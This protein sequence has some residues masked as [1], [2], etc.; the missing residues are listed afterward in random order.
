M[1]ACTA[2]KADGKYVQ[3]SDRV[4]QL[5]SIARLGFVRRSR[6]PESKRLLPAAYAT[7]S[8]A[9]ATSALCRAR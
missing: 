9:T 6:A 1:H 7:A 3:G 4:E 2:G 8:A 5:A